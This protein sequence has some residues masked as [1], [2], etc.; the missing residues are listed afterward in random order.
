[1][2]K[3]KEYEIIENGW[4]KTFLSNMKYFSL[5]QKNCFI[6]G[7]MLWKNKKSFFSDTLVLCVKNIKDLSMWLRG[8]YRT[9][10]S[11]KRI[12]YYIM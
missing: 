11:K 5:S 12:G 2:K 6:N 8:A 10:K 9:K 3:K 4:Y 1:L 7:I